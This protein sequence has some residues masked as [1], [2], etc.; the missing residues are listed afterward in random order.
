MY[1]VRGK[2]MSY[3]HIW[4]DNNQSIWFDLQQTMLLR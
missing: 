3:F 4:V 1:L 2:K